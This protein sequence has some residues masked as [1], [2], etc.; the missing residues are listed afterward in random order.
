VITVRQTEASRRQAHRKANGHDPDAVLSYT[1]RNAGED[2]G[3]WPPRGWLIYETFCR[4]FL[5]ALVARG[6]AG[7]TALRLAQAMAV[8][9]GL[10]LTGQKVFRRCNVL[11]VSLE[12]DELELSRRI[13]AARRRFGVSHEQLLD[14]FF[15]ICPL[16]FQLAR[17]AEHDHAVQPGPL[18]SLLD[19]RIPQHRIGLVVI[20]PFIKAAG[21]PENDNASIDFVCAMLSKL[22]SDHDCAIDVIH[23]VSKGFADPGDSDK[24]RGAS[25][26]RDAARLLATAVP[27][28]PIEAEHYGCSE[29]ERRVL[30]RVDLGKAN[31]TPNLGR[32]TWFHLEGVALDNGTEEYPAGDRIQVALAWDP[33][34]LW[35]TVKPVEERI[36]ARIDL[37]PGGMRRYSPSITASPERAAWRVVAEIADASVSKGQA[38]RAIDSWLKTGILFRRRYRDPLHRKHIVGLYR[39]G[40]QVAPN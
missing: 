4:R 24:S 10:E 36:L 40:G 16:G 12:D 13:E 17:F 26:L 15:Y 32:A 28:S 30:C 1:A 37:G 11:Y 25:A 7:K 21:V 33:P 20:D 35:D 29:S 31:I 19:A 14:A 23:H 9:T 8:A 5:S 27:M 39:A 34:D 3:P 18:Y 6:G 2:F 38:Q 22:A